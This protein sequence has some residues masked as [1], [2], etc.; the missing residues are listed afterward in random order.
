MKDTGM[1]ETKLR[2]GRNVEWRD[3]CKANMMEGR[4]KRKRDNDPDCNDDD[5]A[6][7]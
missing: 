2:I 3:R 7:K 1:K 6:G 5:T 4:F